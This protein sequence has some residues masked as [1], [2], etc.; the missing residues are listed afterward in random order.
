MFDRKTIVWHNLS[1]RRNPDHCL[2][3]CW[4]LSSSRQT[5]AFY[6]IQIN[7]QHSPVFS[8]KSAMNHM[9]GHSNF[10]FFNFECKCGNKYCRAAE[11]VTLSSN[12][13]ASLK[14][15]NRTNIPK[16][17]TDACKVALGDYVPRCSSNDTQILQDI[18]KTLQSGLQNADEKLPKKSKS[19]QQARRCS[20][21]LRMF[22]HIRNEDDAA[23]MAN[24]AIPRQYTRRS[25][26]VMTN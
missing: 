11:N 5:A 17:V 13:N 26:S 7:L 9:L 3:E 24:K 19:F 14:F 4:R 1:Q 23:K 16:S 15:Q 22:L 8:T 12:Q 18:S 10:F 20:K 2:K 6:V 21:P 25:L